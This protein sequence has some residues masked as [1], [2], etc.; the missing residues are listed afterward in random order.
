[1]II[2][3]LAKE[4]AGELECLGENTEKYTTFSA[5]IKKEITKKD[6][7]RNDKITKISYKTKF[8]D[9]FRF[10]SSSLASLVDN[11]ADINRKKCDNKCEYI[12]FKDKNC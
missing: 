10:I 1:M 6:K 2:N 4:F 8:I 7:D 11:L 5:P 9:S 12:G 3:D